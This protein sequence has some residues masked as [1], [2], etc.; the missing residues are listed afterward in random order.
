[1]NKAANSRQGRVDHLPRT[2]DDVL[3]Y[4]IG[5]VQLLLDR[6]ASL[7]YSDKCGLTAHH[8]KVLAAVGVWGPLQAAQVSRWA[9]VDKAAVSRAVQGLMKKGLLERRLYDRD[10]PKLT[11]GLTSEG[12]SRFK[13]ISKGIKELQDNVFHGFD[14]N[15]VTLLFQTLILIEDRLRHIQ[16]LAPRPQEAL[17]RGSVVAITGSTSK[18]RKRQG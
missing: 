5:M 6:A 4:R 11:L 2:L 13:L 8:W 7:V 16:G 1:M 14:R 3:T 10:G 15:H 12:L 18:N 17:I 9:T